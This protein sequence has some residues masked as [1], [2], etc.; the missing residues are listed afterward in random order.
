[1]SPNAESYLSRIAAALERIADRLDELRL[2]EEV[3]L[4][5]LYPVQPITPR[6]GGRER[7]P[8]R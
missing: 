5:E 2:D 6:R 8:G 7:E 4:T 1:M 3:D